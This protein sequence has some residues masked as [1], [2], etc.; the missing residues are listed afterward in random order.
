MGDGSVDLPD[1]GASE[2]DA[3]EDS[4]TTTPDAGTS[5][6]LDAPA[7]SAELGAFI[8]A[9]SY[10]AWQAESGIHPSMGPHFG[11]VRTY[12]SPTLFASLEAD[13]QTH[14]VGS[15]VIKE[16]YA[17]G[18]AVLGHA[19]MGKVSTDAGDDLISISSGVA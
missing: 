1:T 16:L 19:A 3:G 12:V 5:G 9:R 4:A 2:M 14:P 18:D 11:N 15:A 6:D 8:E 17:N 13:N 10:V 7:S